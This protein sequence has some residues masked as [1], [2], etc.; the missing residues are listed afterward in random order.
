MLLQ[1]DGENQTGMK[2]M[3]EVQ[4]VQAESITAAGKDWIVVY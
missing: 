2:S 1:E 3:L 4:L